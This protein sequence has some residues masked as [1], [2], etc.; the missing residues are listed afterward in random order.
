LYDP[1]DNPEAAL[2]RQSVVLQL[3]VSEHY[4]TSAQADNARREMSALLSSDGFAQRCTAKTAYK[5]PHFVN[6][7]RAQ[8]EQ[9]YGPE[10]VYKGGL[11]VTTTIDPQMQAIVE[12]EASKQIAALRDKNVT[13]AAVVM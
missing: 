2:E 5:F 7:V 10:V 11:Q 1:C 4:I 9:Q 13:N 3:M 12:E 6:Y 8:L